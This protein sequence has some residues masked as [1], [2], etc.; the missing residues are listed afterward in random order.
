[1]LGTV[2]LRSCDMLGD[3]TAGF[4][5][6]NADSDGFAGLSTA[7]DV[8]CVVNG[9]IQTSA[10]MAVHVTAV[11]IQKLERVRESATL[12][13]IRVARYRGAAIAR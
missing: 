13:L 8:T 10:T 4:V 11:G 7:S 3:G 1:M 9:N 2:K 6:F 5:S 12:A